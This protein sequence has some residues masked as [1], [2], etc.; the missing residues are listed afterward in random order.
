MCICVCLSVYH[1]CSA[2]GGQRR[3]WSPLELELQVVM[4]SLICVLRAELQPPAKTASTLN[5]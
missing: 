3:V 5:S 1:I 2:C 4:N